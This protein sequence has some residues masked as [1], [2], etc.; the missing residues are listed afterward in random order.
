MT[1]KC[2]ISVRRRC[3]STFGTEWVGISLRG[4]VMK[5]FEESR[6][7]AKLNSLKSALTSSPFP[8]ARSTF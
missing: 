5:I 3:P 7:T 8:I 2:S 1:V 6:T 4:I